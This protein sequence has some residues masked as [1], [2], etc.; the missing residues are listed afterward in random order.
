MF[1]A[2]RL[3]PGFKDNLTASCAAKRE[4]AVILAEDG[5]KHWDMALAKI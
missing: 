5:E 1:Y 3:E 4:R 2:G